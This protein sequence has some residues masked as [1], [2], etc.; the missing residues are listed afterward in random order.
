GVLSDRLSS[1]LLFSSGLALSGLACVFFALSGNNVLVF[2]FLWF[3]NGF[4]QGFGWPSCAKFLKN[5]FAPERFGTY[6]SL[7]SA[8]SNIAGT[9]APMA[10]SFITLNFGWRAT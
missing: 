6:W 9:L 4:A 5:W 1:R 3:C 10:A 2:A 8:S 7:L